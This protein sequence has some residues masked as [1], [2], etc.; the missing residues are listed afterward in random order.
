M[1]DELWTR[2]V[3]DFACAHKHQ[4]V[5]RNHLLKSL[6]PLYLARVASFVTETRHLVSSEVEERIERVVPL[7]RKQQ[8]VPCFPLGRGRE[9]APGPGLPQEARVEV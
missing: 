6:T 3:M 1:E 5:A 7:I 9:T 4:R 8:A 2:V